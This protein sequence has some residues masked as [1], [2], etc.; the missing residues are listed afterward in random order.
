MHRTVMNQALEIG[1][2]RENPVH[3]SPVRLDGKHPG[4]MAR[5][6]EGQVIS[7]VSG[8]PRESPLVLPAVLGNPGRPYRSKTWAIP[9]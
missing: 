4:N 8:A 9:I 1:S 7:N 6:S 5:A 3:Y 2:D